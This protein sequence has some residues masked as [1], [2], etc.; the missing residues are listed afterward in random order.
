MSVQH[1]DVGNRSKMSGSVYRLCQC[2]LQRLKLWFEGPV[3]RPRQEMQSVTQQGQPRQPAANY[4]RT[5]AYQFRRSRVMNARRVHD[6]RT[7]FSGSRTPPL[8]SVWRSY[9]RAISKVARTLARH[10]GEMKRMLSSKSRVKSKSDPQ[11]LTMG[12][13]SSWTLTGQLRGIA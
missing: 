10:R 2:L 7:S 13:N 11:P 4:R 12:P 8:K 9:R 3:S 1:G 6:E 5:L